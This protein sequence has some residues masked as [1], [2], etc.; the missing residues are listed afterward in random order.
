[1]T[2]SVFLG[3][4]RRCPTHGRWV[5]RRHRVKPD[6][7]LYLYIIRER[8]YSACCNCAAR[9]IVIVND[10]KRLLGALCIQ[11]WGGSPERWEICTL[12]SWPWRVDTPVYQFILHCCCGKL[13]CYLSLCCG[14]RTL[15]NSASR[16][17]L[18]KRSTHVY[19]I[20]QEPQE[21][22]TWLVTL[23]SRSSIFAVHSRCIH[24]LVLWK[25]WM[26]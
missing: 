21:K 15:R 26:C 5:A 18:R 2:M 16:K 23:K 3:E 6:I 20:W 4:D 19:K 14:A 10:R 9:A 25:V 13:M 1:M 17:G 7:D 8:I 24:T 12:E 11:H 22:M